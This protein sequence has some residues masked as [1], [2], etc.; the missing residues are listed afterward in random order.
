MLECLFDSRVVPLAV[1]VD[2]AHPMRATRPSALKDQAGCSAV[3]EQAP[4]VICKAPLGCTDPAAAVQHN[5]LSPDPTCFRRDRS[6]E[7][8]LKLGEPENISLRLD[9]AA[10]PTRAEM[11]EWQRDRRVVPIVGSSRSLWEL[12]SLLAHRQGA[13]S[14]QRATAR[15]RF[16]LSL[17]K[18]GRRGWITRR[19]ARI[20]VEPHCCPADR[21][22]A[23][24]LRVV[25]HQVMLQE[26]Q[27]SPCMQG[28]SCRWRT[29]EG[30]ANLIS[31]VPG[32]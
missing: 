21:Q 27:R 6:H 29:A 8:D 15:R 28:H 26:T 12:D 4:P 10:L 24:W 17:A 25:G 9:A 2:I 3:R 11:I 7:R 14:D 31:W 23:M 1:V 32:S 18:L 16:F 19:R 13:V 20:F 22:R 30:R 5:A